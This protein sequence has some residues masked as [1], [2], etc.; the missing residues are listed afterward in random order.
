MEKRKYHVLLSPEVHRHVKA[1]AS[2]HGMTIGQYIA[3]LEQ[4]R[5]TARYMDQDFQRRFDALFEQSALEADGNEQGG[6]SAADGFD[7]KA[8]AEQVRRRDQEHGNE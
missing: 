5:K 6:W 7:M 1:S 4:M 2:L 3:G 8:K